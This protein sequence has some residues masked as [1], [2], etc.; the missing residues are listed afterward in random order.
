MP[1]YDALVVSIYRVSIDADNLD[2]AKNKIITSTTEELLKH[3]NDGVT[4]YHGVQE[5]Y[6]IQADS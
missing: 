5:I 3:K 6:E 4:E 2:K 1:K